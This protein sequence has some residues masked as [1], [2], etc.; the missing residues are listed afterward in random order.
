[1]TDVYF[2]SLVSREISK[3][4]LEQ[5][6]ISK[7][8]E[9]IQIYGDI[10]V[11]KV[12]DTLYVTYDEVHIQ[13]HKLHCHVFYETFYE[14]LVLEF[15]VTGN[16]GGT[17]VAY[18]RDC[19]ENLIGIVSFDLEQFVMKRENDSRWV[20]DCNAM[21]GVKYYFDI[22]SESFESFIE[23]M[24]KC[25][26]TD[27]MENCLMSVKIAETQQYYFDKFVERYPIILPSSITEFGK[28]VARMFRVVDTGLVGIQELP[29]EIEVV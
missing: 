5:V 14:N 26:S 1:M 23:K 9:G 7:I 16:D 6:L 18:F 25:K 24:M 21:D 4:E 22:R 11:K 27:Q 17:Y 13:E 28:K 29:I 15:K 20:I 3:E 12:T 8:G 2:N 10:R 19:D